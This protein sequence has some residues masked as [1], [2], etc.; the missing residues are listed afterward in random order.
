[1]TKS[2]DFLI[3]SCPNKEVAMFLDVISNMSG[4]FENLT[5]YE[6]YLV[7]FLYELSD[8]RPIR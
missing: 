5:T 1:M 3:F 4:F 2:I 7:I 6:K 8:P